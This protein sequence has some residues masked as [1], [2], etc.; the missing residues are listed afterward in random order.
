MTLE[1]GD[2]PIVIILR[3]G[4]IVWLEVCCSRLGIPPTLE[5]ADV[6]DHHGV[7]PEGSHSG[8]V[9]G[10]PSGE[11]IDLETASLVAGHD[12]CRDRL[13][14]VDGSAGLL[15]RRHRAGAGR[16]RWGMSRLAQGSALT[17]NVDHPAFAAFGAEGQPLPPDVIRA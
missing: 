17:R 3:W 10:V 8:V 11:Q 12:A 2:S 7:R 14:G 15:E 13:V 4:V 1:S 16:R 6:I 5:P 9:R